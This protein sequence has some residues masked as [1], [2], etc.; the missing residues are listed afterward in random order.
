MTEQSASTDATPDGSY[1]SLKVKL[2]AGH[3]S[4]QARLGY[5]ALTKTPQ[6]ERR[7]PTRMDTEVM[8]SDTLAEVPVSIASE[9]GQ[10]ENGT[11]TVSIVVHL[12]IGRMKFVD[13]ADRH[14]Q[15]LGFLV[16]LLDAGGSFVAGRQAELELALKQTIWRRLP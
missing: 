11:P 8:A 6:V 4:V 7:Q 9:P 5:T 14:L 2:A 10:A 1:H 16:A 12:D 15:K 3:Y 13:R